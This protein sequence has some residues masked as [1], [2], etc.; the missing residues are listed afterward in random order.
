MDEKFIRSAMLL[1]EDGIEIL[2]NS[3]IMVFGIGGVG[4]FTV[5]AL[6]RTGVGKLSLVDYDQISISNLNRQIHS[7]INT[8]G[9]FKVDIM[10]E[11]ILNINPEMEVRAIRE[12]LVEENIDQLISE[13]IDYIVDAIDMVKSKISLIEYA[14]NKDIPIISAM[15]AGN[16]LNPTDLEIADIYNTT[17]CPLARVIRRELR[18]RNIKD[19]KV[20][21][22]KEKPL[23]SKIDFHERVPGSVSFVPSVSGLIIAS[24]VIKDLIEKNKR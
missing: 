19:L 14:K 18:K 11:R 22:S 13:D 23:E 15:G 16:K 20:V 7:D 5:E 8:I 10:K 6:A 2:K 24:E 3:N 17:I 4:S 9:E 12:I 21:Y 1:G